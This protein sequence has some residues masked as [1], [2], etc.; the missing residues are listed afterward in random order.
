MR[1]EKS[2]RVAS[3]EEGVGQFETLYL[4]LHVG[5]QVCVIALCMFQ[6]SGGLSVH[7]RER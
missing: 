1:G 4:R 7:G 6:E 3:A 2:E 5:L